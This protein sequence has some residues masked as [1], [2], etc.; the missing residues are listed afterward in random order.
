MKALLKHAPTLAISLGVLLA[1][2]CGPAEV[3]DP[4]EAS[5]EPARGP[6]TELAEDL[7]RDL[8]R[9]RHPSD[10]G[11]R[12]WL[13]LAEGESATVQVGR[14][15]RW[16][17]H[18][19]A[20]PEGIAEG[21]VLFLQVS[22]FWGWS[23][24]QTARPEVPGFTEVRTAAEGVELR[25]RQADQQLLAIEIGG[26]ALEAGERVEIIYGAGPAGAVADR[27]A[28]RGSRFWIAVDGDGDGVRELI[29]DPPAVEVLPAAPAQLVLTLPST[30][31]PGET[32]R[33]TLA[34]LDAVGNAGVE[35]V[36]EVELEAT[37]AAVEMAGSFEL[38]PGDRGRRTLELRVP[39]AGVLRIRARGP[40]AL[41]GESNPLL[42]SE[43]GERILWGDLQNH[44]NFS[45]GTG[46]PEDLLVYAR[47]V[48]ALDVVAVTDH[49]HWGLPFLDQRPEN[50]REIQHATREAHEPGRFVAL[51]G[52]EWTHWIHGH[53]HVLYFGGEG[54]LLS[55]MDAS[56]DDPLE[57]WAALEGEKALTVAHH[58]A[59]GPI[60]T[61]WSYA[62]DPELETVT[63]IV[64]VHG[65]SEAPDSPRPI[66]QP[67]EG[68]WVRDALD[69]GYKLGFIGSSDGHD[70][71]PGLAHL[72]SASGGL[73]AIFSP[74]LTRDGVYR[75]LR[76][77]HTYATNGPRIVLLTNFGGHPMGSE[78]PASGAEPG[79]VGEVP[80]GMLVT[81][82]IAPGELERID[83]VRSGELAAS[84]PCEGERECSFAVEV[85]D[86]EA[87]EYLYLRV[88]QED[89]GAA[90]SSPFFFT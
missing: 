51:L 81:R 72:A 75:A 13:E 27:F 48:A 45:D 49:D 89:G 11:G 18:Y 5:P 44:S 63:E 53:R 16:A 34:A 55:T 29:A 14:A 43:R 25:A 86:L 17:I 15:G 79:P 78:I 90:W 60:A 3:E 30:A 73:A 2:A 83:V 28:E 82:A 10:G 71:H 88:V 64:S 38:E 41:E 37:G 9:P 50:W 32:V 69:R 58:S 33:L 23:S 74:E 66:Y 6:H 36:G 8:E 77:R 67:I 4:G 80:P 68:N 65:S 1:L 21:G 19:E 40:G 59:G 12:A 39:E 56:T 87:G 57:L 84:A 31:H 76:A 24:P 42:V 22:P 26:R 85:G 46:L 7:R 35:A 61:D 70:G 62:P 54:E 20:G 52:Y 47:D